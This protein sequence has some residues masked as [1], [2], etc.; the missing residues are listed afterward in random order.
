MS[1]LS[2]SIWIVLLGIALLAV[3]A[4]GQQTIPEARW[5]QAATVIGSTFLVHGGKKDPNNSYSYTSAP[6]TA[7]I[8]SLNLATTFS[9][10]NPP[11]SLIDAPNG[12][13]LAFHT[14][15]GYSQHELLYFGGDA[16]PELPLSTR[17]D[18]AGTLWLSGQR[19]TWTT[20]PDGWASQPMRR[21]Y[22][23]GTSY[24]GRVIISGGEKVDGSDFAFQEAYVFAPS[25]SRSS[26]TALATEN[27]PPDLVG[28]STITLPN[29]TMFV[30]GGYSRSQSQMLPMNL[31]YTFNINDGTWSNF[32]TQGDVVPAGRR[33]FAAVLIGTDA[34]VI[35]GGADAT[36]SQG[37]ADGFIF[38]MGSKQWTNLPALNDGLGT[39]WG[40]SAVSVGINVFF[41]YGYTSTGPA[42][43][44]LTLYDVSSGTFLSSFSPPGQDAP[45]TNSP[46]VPP[47]P[48][49]GGGGGGGGGGSDSQPG[50][51]TGNT[52]PGTGSG[53]G[54]T[55]SNGSPPQTGIPSR[56][57][58]PV[59]IGGIFGGLAATAVII[60][61][62][63]VYRRRRGR[64]HRRGWSGA[65]DESEKA[66]MVG[67]FE[68]VPQGNGF[69]ARFFN[70]QP[71]GRYMQAPKRQRF[72]ILAD[73]DASE[74]ASR[75]RPRSYRMGTGESGGSY[76]GYLTRWNSQGAGSAVASLVNASVSSFKSAFGLNNPPPPPS[77]E[78]KHNSVGTRTSI[79][80]ARPPS[81]WRR[82]SSYTSNSR[83]DPFSDEYGVEEEYQKAMTMQH[84]MLR[85]APSS[86]VEGY[87]A[88]VLNRNPSETL[89][90]PI[91]ESSRHGAGALIPLAPVA[92]IS[93]DPSHGSDDAHER[94]KSSITTHDASV[95][96]PP[97]DWSAQSHSPRV[98]SP[99]PSYQQ[100]QQLQRAT[101]AGSRI[102]ASLTRTMSVI[103]SLF[104]GSND[105]QGAANRGKAGGTP[106]KIKIG[107]QAYDYMDLRDP[108]PPPPHLGMPLLPV[109]EV[110]PEP[111]SRHASR[112][113]SGSDGFGTG[114]T[115]RS[116]LVLKPL[117]GKSLSS[118]R[119]ANSEALERLGTGHWNVAQRDGTGSSRRT[120]GSLTSMPDSQFSDLV[121]G[122]PGGSAADMTWREVIGPG[123]GPG[124]GFAP[125]PGPE[126]PVVESPAELETPD[127][128]LEQQ[129]PP[130]PAGPRPIP[131]PKRVSYSLA[132]RIESL[133]MENE[134]RVPLQT[135]AEVAETPLPPGAP[136]P[137]NTRRGTNVYGIVP[138]P[139]LYIANPERRTDS[140]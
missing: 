21:Q 128:F 123:P 87:S 69:V 50:S 65:T 84:E 93:T 37:Y 46:D 114:S 136:E 2:Q 23:S 18:S 3:V 29:G 108:N 53:N 48:P 94:Q 139:T 81:A 22:H 39:R 56:S 64:R 27:G 6:N 45:N 31:I 17:N 101:S 40:H 28:H 51:S 113:L 83:A 19:A 126:R 61:L 41:L 62:V 13:A 36:L 119:T 57:S 66:V 86:G 60:I 38:N 115:G 15:T 20:H 43:N 110:V 82:G 59:V 8:Y 106:K 131:P 70:L 127:V 89:G 116:P 99:P 77:R 96:T 80:L 111:S 44:A 7:E 24:G 76:G 1:I 47:D 67:G 121:D 103:S 54:D 14:I 129:Q 97:V 122:G 52:D 71:K 10:D 34:F 79:S 68:A 102:G 140:S 55:G 90:P 130:S 125:V 58:T 124:P 11:W 49:S 112:V 137:M 32:N 138:K 98:Y 75:P 88:L 105:H 74:Y 16:G 104:G 85:R 132:H 117:H 25:T 63:V 30:F 92:S 109:E 4:D 9:L 78:L 135:P 134:A 72:D 35:H 118:L 12:P 73:E 42:S 26:F 33:N 133:G 95:R 91:A 107:S 100:Q 120:D 5:G